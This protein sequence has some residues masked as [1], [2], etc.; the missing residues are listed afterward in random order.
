M[1]SFRNDHIDT[2][3][4]PL[5]AASRV[6]RPPA[7][8][9][10][11]SPSRESEAN[12]SSRDCRAAS[13]A[14]LGSVGPLE[15]VLGAG[16]FSD[17]SKNRSSSPPSSSELD[18]SSPSRSSSDE[19]ISLVREPRGVAC[20]A[21]V[22]TERSSSAAR[23]R[24]AVSASPHRPCCCAAS[25]CT[26]STS[27]RA[28]SPTRSTSA[29]GSPARLSSSASSSASMEHSPAICCARSISARSYSSRPPSAGRSGSGSG[30][31]SGARSRPR[32]RS[33]S[34]PNVLGTDWSRRLMYSQSSSR[35]PATTAGSAPRPRIL[36]GSRGN[37]LRCVPI[38]RASCRCSW[39]KRL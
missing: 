34:G 3:P 7:A 2:S 21:S 32:K 27:A 9:A 17:T 4:K 16:V 11:P 29:A 15:W 22:R 35:R 6:L 10:P 37:W 31:G 5:Y 30:S 13:A 12:R 1:T 23:S 36:G 26:A 28:V 8:P 39:L 19:R 25:P 18:S 38:F 24:S 14:L 20:S 33:S